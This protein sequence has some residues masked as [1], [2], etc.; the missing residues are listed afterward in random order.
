V[1]IALSAGDTRPWQCGLVLP[2][3]C[4]RYSTDYTG[5]RCMLEPRAPGGAVTSTIWLYTSGRLFTSQ[6]VQLEN[7]L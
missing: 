7:R 4:R 5:G 1:W 6:T 3:R 2:A